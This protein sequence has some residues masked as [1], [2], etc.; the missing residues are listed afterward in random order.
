MRERILLR[1]IGQ[2]AL[3]ALDNN[4]FTE[5]EWNDWM[6]EVAMDIAIMLSGQ[7]LATFEDVRRVI[8]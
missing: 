1:H 5:T 8:E 6:Q 4:D 2:Q 7:Q 3:E